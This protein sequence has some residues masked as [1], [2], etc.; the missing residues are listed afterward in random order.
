[1]ITF[2]FEKGGLESLD[3]LDKL[4]WV[5]EE[6]TGWHTFKLLEQILSMQLFKDRNTHN[7]FSLFKIALHCPEI[8]GIS[9]HM[10][11]ISL[12]IPIHVDIVGSLVHLDSR[13]F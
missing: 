9:L 5:Q 11:Y 10:M 7:R 6:V 13:L 2:P 4:I 3:G 1:M 8:L 12:Y